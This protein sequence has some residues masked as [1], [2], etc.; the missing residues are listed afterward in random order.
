MPKWCCLED[1]KRAPSSYYNKVGGFECNGLC[2]LKLQ[3][4]ELQHL[5]LKKKR[6]PFKN[7]L[8]SS[9]PSYY[10]YSTQ[11]RRGPFQYLTL[12]YPES[13][14]GLRK[15]GEEKKSLS[16]SSYGHWILGEK[17]DNDDGHL[18]FSFLVGWIK[19]VKKTYAPVVY[20]SFSFVSLQLYL[21]HTIDSQTFHC[22]IN[23]SVWFPF[24]RRCNWQLH[25]R[26]ALVLSTIGEF[27]LFKS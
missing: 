20:I 11:I 10:T 18:F 22:C 8:P 19:K 2:A 17:D 27:F 14:V 4:G 24:G 12:L 6:K 16:S 13:W 26:L 9:L 21:I 7:G 3:S 25:F 23:P 5:L 15:E 1:R